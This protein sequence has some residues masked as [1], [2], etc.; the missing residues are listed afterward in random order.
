MIMNEYIFYTTEGMTL[1]PNEDEEEI[2][3]CQIL[4]FV[5]AKNSSEAKDLLLEN[6]PWIV[7]AGYSLSEIK[8]KQVLTK[9]QIKDI[10]AIVDY[11]FADEE[12]HYEECGDHPKEHIFEV[13][14][15]LKQIY[16][17]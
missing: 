6:N 11:N 8:I 1:P 3:N 13:L 14:K 15:R 9:E 7:E 16:S 10:Q 17:T 2:D 5:E 4:G 12:K